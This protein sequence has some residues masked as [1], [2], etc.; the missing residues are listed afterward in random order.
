MDAPSST[1]PKFPAPHLDRRRLLVLGTALAGG[2]VLAGCSGGDDGPAADPADAGRTGSEN[3]GSEN[4]GD[5]STSDTSAPDDAAETS[6]G[7][8]ADT[9]FTAADFEALGVCRLLP[10]LTAG[11]FPTRVQMERRDITESHAGEPL[12]VGIRVVDESCEPISG[13][14]VEIWHCDVDG[15]YSSYTDGATSDDDAEGTTFLRG[16]QVTNDD[17]IVEFVTIWP[18]WYQ[19]RAIHIHSAIHIDD[20]TVLTTQ[21]LFDDDLNAEVMASGRYAAHGQPDTTNAEDGV[22]RGNA[23]ADGLLFAVADDAELGGRRALILVGVD[24]G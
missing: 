16:N 1:P 14:R 10:E 13:A 15:D 2:T 9:V 21:Y 6:T 24:S 7:T 19:G 17:G 22:T 8:P 4:T 5:G 23:A 11:P 18:G 20:S 3:T 12:R